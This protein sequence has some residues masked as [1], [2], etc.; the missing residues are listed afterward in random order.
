MGDSM[1]VLEENIQSDYKYG[2]TSDIETEAFE[3]GL[4]EDTVR[5][6]SAKKEEPEWLLEYRLK[7]FKHWQTLKEPHWPKVNYPPIKYQDIIYYA[8]PKKKPELAS[9]DEVDPEL[10]K[11]F[12]KLGIPLEEQMILAGVAVD[13][14]IDSVSIKTTYKEKLGEL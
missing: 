3:P 11:T 8:E 7:A 4:S 2:F 10:V 13:A 9:M 1:Q 6:I 14:V 5:R 12:N